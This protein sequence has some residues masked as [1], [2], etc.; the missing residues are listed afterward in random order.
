[1]DHNTKTTHHFRTSN[2]IVPA[3][4]TA[5]TKVNPQDTGNGVGYYLQAG[6]NKIRPVSGLMPDVA[7]YCDGSSCG[8]CL[9]YDEAGA[10]G[11]QQ[12]LTESAACGCTFCPDLVEEH[13]QAA[14]AVAST[15]AM[16]LEPLP[17][18]MVPS[19]K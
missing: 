1:M 8:Y 11:E 5:F 12:L 7:A 16:A 13:L 4:T 10:V 15:A 9:E 6:H 19:G 2:S 14:T 18:A 17:V 3:K